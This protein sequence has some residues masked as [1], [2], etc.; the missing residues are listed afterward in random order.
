MAGQD[1]ANLESPRPDDVRPVGQMRGLMLIIL[2]L[3]VVAGGFAVGFYVGQEM[4][5]KNAVSANEARLVRELEQQREELAK[6]REEAKKRVPDVTTTQVGELTFYNEL[7]KQSVE[8]EPLDAQTGPERTTAKETVISKPAVSQKS[9]ELLKE[10]IEQE[11]NRVEK[12]G[13]A[14]PPAT[15]K[16][17][18]GEY[19]LQLA[20]FQ[21][22]DEAEKFL[23]RLGSAGFS[24]TIRSVDISGRG[25]W[26]RVY[27]GPFVTRQKAEEAK[28]SAKEKLK[29]DGLVV[30][31]G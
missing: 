17:A 7:P 6:L 18:S 15:V 30:K 20:S 1:F 29:I 16:P 21:K 26:Y 2:A 19:F 31:G 23:P 4:G 27:A 3:I 22:K 28:S 9:D 24:G 11:L 25:V 5:K 13:S 14:L 12:T 8:P 10:I